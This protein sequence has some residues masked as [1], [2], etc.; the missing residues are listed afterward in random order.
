MIMEFNGMPKV[1]DENI[2]LAKKGAKNTL[3]VLLVF[4]YYTF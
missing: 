1:H 2:T 4:Q 3:P